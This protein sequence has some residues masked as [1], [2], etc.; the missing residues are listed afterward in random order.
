[1]T[2][3]LGAG[4]VTLL[5]CA[6]PVCSFA[7]SSNDEVHATGSNLLRY[8]TGSTTNPLGEDFDKNYFEEIADVRLFYQ[9]LSIGLRYEMDDPSEVGRSWTDRDFRR[10][11]ITYDKDHVQLTAGDVP[12]LFG[13]G[14]AVNMFESRPL[15]Y[16]SWL[17]GIFGKT[18]Y[19]IP[20]D[21]L[22]V[23]ATVRIQAVG[24]Q[25]DFNPIDTTQPIMHISARAADAEFGFFHQKLIFGADFVQAYTGTSLPDPLGSPFVTNR[26]VNEPDFYADLNSGDFEAFVEWSEDRTHVDQFLS[27]PADTS[28]MG[29]A[30]YTSLSY[31]NSW[32]GF[33]FDY[34]NYSYFLHDPGDAYTNVFSKLPISSPPEVYK[35]F[36]YTEITRTTHAV[37]FDDEVGYQL[38]ANITAIPQ[39]AIDLDA[40]ASSSHDKYNSEGIVT[41]S[42]SILPKLSDQGFYPFWEAFAEAEWDF[43]PANQE[44]FARLA[45]HRRSDVIGYTASS[46]SATDYRY[47]TTV[48]AKFQYETAPNQSFLGEIEHQWAYDQSLPTDDKRRLNELLTLQYSFDPVI[49]FGAIFDYG[50]Y[51]ANGPV[52]LDKDLFNGWSLHLWGNSA[53][54]HLPE[55]FASTR[56]GASHT[57]LLQYGAERGGI[58]CTGGIC[59]LV[60][61]FKGFRITLTSQI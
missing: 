22:D 51:Y 18:E 11:W 16:D 26:Q 57:L 44:N 23:G 30:F 27:L 13:R 50:F 5:T 49:T 55:F 29:H 61:A 54:N 3:A 17:D 34:K 46:P 36:T 60:P 2:F 19:A 7:Q 40:A 32:I 58:N 1:M 47:A 53:I 15:N 52:T 43:D 25:E 39:V 20:K 45:I 59:R 38:E 56:L 6:A 35:D 48:A 21:W 33:T 37:N 9:Y 8:G 10:R 12:A 42:T 31:S 41:D 4:I 24:G 28:H 14:L